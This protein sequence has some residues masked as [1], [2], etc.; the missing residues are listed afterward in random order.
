M[1][2]LCHSM[3]LRESLSVSL[4]LSSTYYGPSTFLS[5]KAG[6]G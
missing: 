4:P 5:L 2:V 6:P 3:T 1:L